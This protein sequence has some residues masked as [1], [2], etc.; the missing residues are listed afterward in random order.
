VFSLSILSH[1]QAIPT[2]SKLG[3]LQLGVGVTNVDT[4]YTP[5]YDRGIT[6]YGTFDVTRHL[7]VE[8][9]LHFASISAPGDVGENSYLI[10]PRYVWKISRFHPYAKALFGVGRINYQ[11]DFE[12]YYAETYAM[13]ALGGGVDI[14]ATR[15]INVRAIDV[16]FQNWPGYSVHGLS[17]IVTTIGVA[18]SF[19]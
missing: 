6:V 15:R 14:Q 3:T 5:S 19:P 12:P 4:D 10:G 13:Y 17:P 7:G 11:F 16:E 18:Y 1:A 9:D 8:G 2:A